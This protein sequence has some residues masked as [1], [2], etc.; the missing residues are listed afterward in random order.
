MGATSNILADIPTELPDELFQ[1]L[2]TT[3]K[4]RIERIVSRG[5]HSPESYWYDQLESEWILLLAGAARLQFE[6]ETIA[7]EPGSFVNIAARRR[8]RVEWT[9]PNEDTIWL[10]IHYRDCS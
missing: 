10:A 4:V 2:L 9:A 6:D 8:H 7:M 1:N 3:A 5:H